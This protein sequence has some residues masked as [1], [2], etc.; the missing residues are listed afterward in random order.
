MKRFT[1]DEI[2]QALAENDSMEQEGDT[3]RYFLHITEAGRILPTLAGADETF[4][5][6]T[7]VSGFE[8]D[9]REEYETLQNDAFR[10][11]CESLRDQANDF[12]ERFGEE[13]PDTDAYKF[14]EELFNEGTTAKMTVAIARED[15]ENF[16]RTGWYIPE[17]LTAE[18]YT[19]I[20]NEMV[21]RY[22]E[23]NK[24]N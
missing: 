3:A 14:M 22:I 9:W 13:D 2:A 8:G 24:E 17:D 15:L 21:D 12:M 7:D 11:V 6:D 19:E 20:W 16:K 23:A 18:R 5:A 4:T 1:I 10:D